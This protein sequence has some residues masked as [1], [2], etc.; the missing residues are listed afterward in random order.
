M[1]IGGENA[2]NPFGENYS[3]ESASAEEVG[4]TSLT[5]NDKLDVNVVV[6]ED[7]DILFWFTIEGKAVAPGTFNYDF[8]IDGAE[9]A[10]GEHVG[11]YNTFTGFSRKTLTAGTYNVKIRFW[12]DGTNPVSARRA[13]LC[14]WLAKQ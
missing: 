14:V 6:E 11:G 13:R 1:G 10:G 4:Y 8:L 2:P 7:A 9:N 5:P 3:Y 12:A